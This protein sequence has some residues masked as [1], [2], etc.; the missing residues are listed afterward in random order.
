MPDG[1][2]RLEIHCRKNNFAPSNKTSRPDIA[3]PNDVTLRSTAEAKDA[4]VASVNRK[5]S[6][7]IN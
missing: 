2:L 5:T 1:I 3:S 7:S 4:N 6:K